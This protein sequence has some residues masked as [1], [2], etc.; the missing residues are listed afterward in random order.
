[1][2]EITCNSCGVVIGILNEIVVEG[3]SKLEVQFQ[4]NVSCPHCLTR[5]GQVIQR[6]VRLQA[7]QILNAKVYDDVHREDKS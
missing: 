3:M 2:N 4:L 6:T 5:Q 7:K 1:M